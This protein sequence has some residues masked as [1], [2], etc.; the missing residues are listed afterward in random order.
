MMSVFVSNDSAK[1]TH[2]CILVTYTY[3]HAIFG[4]HLCKF[5]FFFFLELHPLRKEVPGL[6]IESELQLPATA[7]ATAMQDPSCIC[8]L[9]HSSRQHRILT[10]LNRARDPT[11]ILMGPS[12]VLN[13]L[14]PNRTPLLSMLHKGNWA[15]RGRATHQVT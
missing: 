9:H 5:F 1:K 12:W 3:M 14:S 13:P 10:P 6:G 8:D 11:C 7:T 15:S 4:T 2:P